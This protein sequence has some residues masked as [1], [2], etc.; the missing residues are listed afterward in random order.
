MQP[1]DAISTKKDAAE[2]KAG[3]K[4]VT[5]AFLPTGINTPILSPFSKFFEKK[6]GRGKENFFAKSFPS[7]E[8]KNIQLHFQLCIR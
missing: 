1:P 4:T 2:N 8:N 5:K 7:P 3:R 6:G